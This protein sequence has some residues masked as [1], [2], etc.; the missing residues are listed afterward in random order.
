MFVT[1]KDLHNIKYSSDK[2]EWHK[3]VDKTYVEFKKNVDL[4]DYWLVGN[5]V[6]HG[7]AILAYNENMIAYVSQFYFKNIGNDV[8][9][10]VCNIE[11]S[12]YVMDRT[13]KSSVARYSTIMGETFELDLDNLKES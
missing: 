9:E 1:E 5:M 11:V 4:D 3:Y 7:W 6:A 12:K 2:T 8:W 13:G 10:H